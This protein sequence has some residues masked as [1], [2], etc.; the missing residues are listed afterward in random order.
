MKLTHFLTKH[1][2]HIIIMPFDQTCRSLNIWTFELEGKETKI[3]MK[4]NHDTIDSNPGTL[5]C[6]AMY[7]FKELY[8]YIIE[9][10]MVVTVYKM[11]QVVGS[12]GFRN[13][14]CK[15]YQCNDFPHVGCKLE[16]KVN[17]PLVLSAS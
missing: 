6:K 13:M 17:E 16:F 12:I 14:V 8:G 5:I 2:H 10:E 7:R 4:V 1:H 3:A 11:G 15:W 9:K